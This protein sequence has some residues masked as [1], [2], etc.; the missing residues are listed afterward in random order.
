[1]EIKHNPCRITLGQLKYLDCNV[2]ERY[3]PIRLTSKADLFGI[4]MLKDL[5]PGETEE[6]VETGSDKEKKK[7][8]QKINQN[9]NQNINLFQES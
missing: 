7:I 2:D 1:M 3:K 8:K 9:I 5:K 4:V 6:F